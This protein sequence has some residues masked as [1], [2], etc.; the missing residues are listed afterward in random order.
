M[1]DMDADLFN[2]TAELAF[3]LELGKMRSNLTGA[4]QRAGRHNV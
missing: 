2:Q 4:G 1:P 3:W